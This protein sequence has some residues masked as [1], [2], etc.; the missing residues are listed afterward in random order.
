MPCGG[1][2]TRHGA[3]G[4]SVARHRD[5]ASLTRGRAKDS[6]FPGPGALVRTAE[7]GGRGQSLGVRSTVGFCVVGVQTVQEFP[8]RSL[9][10]EHVEDHMLTVPSNDFV[11]V[12]WL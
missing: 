8:D 6:A 11:F 1:P 10:S 2:G 3:P 5:D 9:G 12:L 7:P 4:S